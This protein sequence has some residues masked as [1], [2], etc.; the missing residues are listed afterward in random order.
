MLLHSFFIIF[1]SAGSKICHLWHKVYF[2]LKA[3]KAQKTQEEPLAFP[4][5][6]KKT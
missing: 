1:A 2:E 3:V 5:L 6:S 4:Q